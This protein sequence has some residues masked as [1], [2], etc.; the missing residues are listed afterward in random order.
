MF[1]KLLLRM[2]VN[3]MAVLMI[4]LLVL[5]AL[6]SRFMWLNQLQSG[7]EDMKQEA[8]EIAENYEYLYDFQI[9]SRVFSKCIN[10]AATD[11]SVWLLDKNG[12]RLNVTGLDETTPD[13]TTEDAQKYLRAV[14]ESGEAMVFQ[15][16]FEDYF[17]KS[18]VV[19]VAMPLMSRDETVGAVFIPSQ[20]RHVQH[21]LCA[22]VPRALDGLDGR[23]PAGTHPDG[24]Y[25]H[26]RHAPP[27]GAGPAPPSAWVR[28]IC[29]LRCASMRTTRSARCPARSTIWWT[30]CKTWK[31]SARV[32][33]PTSPMS[34]ARPSRPSR[35][36][37]RGCSTGTIPPEEQHKYMQ[38]STTKLSA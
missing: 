14:L 34:C 25:R 35:V 26:A 29:R 18:A 23:Q 22:A 28:A 4:V 16:G 1:H 20:A 7:L 2:S 24:L 6:V 5:G 8:E 31:S 38:V 27:A 37:C 3:F 30:H 9:S 21:R 33:S 17:G 13:L 15:N 10:D 12:L 11:S 36:M 32:S 19:T